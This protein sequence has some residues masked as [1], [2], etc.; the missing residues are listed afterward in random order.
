MAT[1]LLWILL[2]LSVAAL[3][4]ISSP[5]RFGLS[6]SFGKT[7]RASCELTAS[8]IHPRLFRYSYSSTSPETRK[9]IFGFT[10]GAGKKKG[11]KKD[12]TEEDG[13]GGDID[14]LVDY[15]D[16][17]IDE[18]HGNYEDIYKSGDNHSTGENLYKSKDNPDKSEDTYKSAENDDHGKSE[19]TYKSGDD[20]SKSENAHKSKR[21][22]IKPIIENFNNRI[23]NIKKGRPY[24]ILTRK[25]LR[26][27]CFKW[28][29][30]VLK[31][32]R[33]FIKFDKFKLHTEVGLSDPAQVGKAFGYFTAAQSA[34]GLQ[35]SRKTSLTM[36][37]L[38]TEERFDA[39]IELQG[40]TTLAA[41]LAGALAIAL[42]FPYSILWHK[43][44]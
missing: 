17:Y 5:I 7:R 27:K 12:K 30:V 10:L 43:R 22:R 23:D 21:F 20:H 28:L 32:L 3:A 6:A 26:D 4:V 31:R 9:V 18:N 16:E 37:P 39:D 29:R 11:K 13:E 15:N 24:R 8:Y 25:P 19:D 33:L 41:L 35:K 36:V 14:E 1:V 34:L 2:A 44:S 38:F 42:T 40:R